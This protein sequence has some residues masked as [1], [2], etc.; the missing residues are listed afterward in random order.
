ME[1]APRSSKSLQARRAI[2]L[3]LAGVLGSTSLVAAVPALAAPPKDAAPAAVG[4]ESKDRAAE[5][6]ATALKLYK[7]GQYRAAIDKLIEARK[8]DPTAKELPYNLGLVYEKLGELDDAIKNF[9]LYLT[10]ETDIDEM[11]RVQATIDRLEGARA[12]LEKKQKAEQP[13][14]KPV[15]EKPKPP[16]IVQPEPEPAP[17]KKGKL[18][19][20]VYGTAGLA[21]V[22]AA[23][24][25]VLGLRALS[26]RPD[27]PPTTT[28]SKSYADLQSDADSAHKTAVMAD[29]AFGV[30]AVSAVTAVVLYFTREAPVVTGAVV[31]QPGG[32]SLGVMGRFLRQRERRS[33]RLLENHPTFAYSFCS[34]GPSPCQKP[35]D[36]LASFSPPPLRR[37]LVSPQR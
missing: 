23:A 9:R 22:G 12:E 34:S 19:G 5:A 20:W 3:L 25:T 13:V 7:G 21:V 6:Y 24:G 11:E 2:A 37:S 8:L 32:A 31:P 33:T 10:L 4:T 26:Q 35:C 28:S 14:E 18:D 27:D 36:A 29:V 15:A 1:P 17:R 30:A 16:P